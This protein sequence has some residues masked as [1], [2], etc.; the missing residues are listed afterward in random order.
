V[1]R[2]RFQ[3]GLSIAV[4]ALVVLAIAAVYLMPKPD[5]RELPSVASS[6]PEGRRALLLVLERLGFAPEAWRKPP[7]ALPHGEHVLWSFGAPFD[8]SESARERSSDESER[9]RDA[10]SLSPAQHGMHAIEHYRA[11]LD[12]GGTLILAW[13]ERTRAFLADGVG[14]EGVDGFE[15]RSPSA[16]AGA[17]GEDGA[18]VSQR[19]RLAD[20]SELAAAWRADAA[21]P[22]TLCDAL[23]RPLWTSA[24]PGEPGEEG[25]VLAATIDVGAGH[26]VLLADDSFTANRRLGRD[27]SAELAVRLIEEQGVTQRL[28][29]DEYALGLWEPQT[30]V[31]LAFSGVRLAVTLHVLA[32]LH[33]LAWM[34]GW[35]RA[36]P[37]DPEP[38]EAVSPVSRARGLANVFVRAR[39]VRDLAAF[40]RRGE[41]ERLRRRARL[42]RGSSGHADGTRAW[43]EKELELASSRL[44][45]AAELPRW[46]KAW[47]ERGVANEAEL[48]AL[49]AELDAAIASAAPASP[50]QAPN[51]RSA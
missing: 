19:V 49:L 43:A 20:G 17:A 35:A 46:R 47:F 34:L 7:G 50:R 39:R 33:V 14:L 11:F 10:G 21:L 26:V 41:L 3:K 31:G 13:N 2:A 22:A 28:L 6:R 30:A 27:A 51:A 25:R 40:A 48:G 23:A 44:G 18:P 16:A 8:P 42:A 32:L 24:E 15:A 9:A 4:G 29:F 38:L 12:A 5:E 36:F 37:R 1:N 45:A